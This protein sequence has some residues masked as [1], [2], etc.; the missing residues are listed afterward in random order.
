MLELRKLQLNDRDIFKVKPKLRLGIR[1]TDMVRLKTLS[2][3]KSPI[4]ALEP[5]SSPFKSKYYRQY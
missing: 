4:I 1:K 3:I 5:I 2:P